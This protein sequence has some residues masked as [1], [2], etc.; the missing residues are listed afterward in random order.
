MFTWIGVKLFGVTVSFVAM[1]ICRLIRCW[2]ANSC[3]EVY[4]I[5]VGLGGLGSSSEICV[6]SLLSLR[7]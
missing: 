1:I 7:Y 6:W 5:T 3:Q 2:D 4:R